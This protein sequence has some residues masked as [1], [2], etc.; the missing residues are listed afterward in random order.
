M[1]ALRWSQVITLVI[2]TFGITYFVFHLV[3]EEVCR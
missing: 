3:V 1:K 2:A